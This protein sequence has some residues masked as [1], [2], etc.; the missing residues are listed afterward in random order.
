MELPR[1][2]STRN[3][4][5]QNRRPASA[6]WARSTKENVR[7]HGTS[8]VPIF[9]M[10]VMSRRSRRDNVRYA[11]SGIDVEAR[12]QPG[13]PKRYGPRHPEYQPFEIL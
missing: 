4:E 2:M 3:L 5:R 12:G 10:T 7:T 9:L 6:D 8:Y 13:L 11:L 1:V